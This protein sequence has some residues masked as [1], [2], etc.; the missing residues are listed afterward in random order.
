MGGGALASGVRPVSKPKLVTSQLKAGSTAPL[1]LLLLV[2]DFEKAFAFA[3]FAFLFPLTC[4]LLHV[5]LK[6]ITD[7]WPSMTAAHGDSGHVTTVLYSYGQCQ[8]IR[9]NRSGP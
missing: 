6:S 9:L 2:S 7:G 3:I 4:V 8:L 5:L 1:A